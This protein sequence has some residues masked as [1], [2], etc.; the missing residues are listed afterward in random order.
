[1]S[2]LS[3]SLLYDYFSVSVR[4]TGTTP[5]PVLGQSYTLECNVS[6]ASSSS[7]SYQWIKNNTI[8]NEIGPIL[9]FKQL[10][11]SDSGKYTCVVINGSSKNCSI[12]I[13]LQRK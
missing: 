1:M 10:R 9:S 11:L 12:D 4:I 8:L 6:G 13:M 3:V 5:D 7:Y 2:A